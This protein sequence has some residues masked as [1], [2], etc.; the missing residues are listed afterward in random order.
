MPKRIFRNYGIQDD[1]YA[2]AQA[3]LFKENKDKAPK[4]RNSI[5]RIAAIAVINYA[6]PNKEK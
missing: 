5:S 4:D 1:I 2:K 6:Y 3:R